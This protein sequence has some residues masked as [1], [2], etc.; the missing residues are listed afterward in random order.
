MSPREREAAIPIDDQLG[1]LIDDPDFQAIQVRIGQ[2]NLFEALGAVHG[3]LRHSNFLGYLLSPN[4]PHGLGSKALQQMLRRLIEETPISRRPLSTL[5]LIVGDLD[6]AIV[7]RERDGIDLL[8]EIDALKLVVFIENKVHAKAGDG[9]LRRYRELIDSRYPA[10][11]KIGIFLTPDGVAPDDPAY[12]P[13][14][15]ATLT[16][17]LEGVVSDIHK[18]DPTRLIVDHYVDMVRRNLVEDTH[19][20]SLAAKLYERHAEAL[21]FIFASRPQPASL[22]EAIA[23][24]VRN[25]PGLIVESESVAMLRFAPEKW[26]DLLSYEIDKREWTHSGR[27]LL[28]E[29]KSYS[30]KRGRVNVSLVLGPGAASYRQAMYAAAQTLPQIFAGLV[31]PM[32]TKW[33]TIFSK[34]LLTPE[35]ASDLSIEAQVSNL[36]LAWSDFQAQTLP[37]LIDAILQIDEHIRSTGPVPN[38]GEVHE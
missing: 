34:D 28:F 31:K 4:R 12:L 33:S 18:S 36:D 14:S 30:N 19:L 3:E 13:L 9:Q 6:D 2:F 25:T 5:E 22:V 11:R 38:L 32:G 35:R 10:Y 17:V 37:L 20:R 24:R 15:Y 26:D 21:D 8:V 23:Y 7:H 16:S 1:A 29:V 27:G